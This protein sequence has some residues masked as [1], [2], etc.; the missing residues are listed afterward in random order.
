MPPSENVKELL[1]MELLPAIG[2]VDNFFRLPSVQ[3]ILEG[4]QVRGRIIESP[5]TLLNQCGSVLEL[6]D[7]IKKHCCRTFTFTCN[8]FASQFLN[9]WM[10]VS[11][12]KAFAKNV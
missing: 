8:T 4:C 7:P 5:V 12:V 3:S 9:Q 2:D 10:K 1:K 6:R 11:I